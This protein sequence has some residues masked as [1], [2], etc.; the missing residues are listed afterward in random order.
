MG[1]IRLFLTS[2]IMIYGGRG[3]LFVYGIVWI[4]HERVRYDYSKWLGPDWKVE[5]AKFNGAG[6]IVAN[7]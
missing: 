1:P 4:K 5:N 6:T 7:H 3:L 2:Q